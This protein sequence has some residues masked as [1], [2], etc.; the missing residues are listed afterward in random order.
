MTPKPEVTT[1]F[2][3]YTMGCSEEMLRQIGRTEEAEK[4][5]AYTVGAKKAY[6]HYYINQE[7]LETEHMACLVRPLAFDLAPQEQKREIAAALNRMAVKR[8][9]TVGTGFL[10]TPYLL[11]ALAENGYLDTAYRMLENTKASG[12]LAMVSQGA[13]TVWEGYLGFDEAG[14]PKNSSMNHYAMGSVCS[15]L[16][17]YVCGIT[18]VAEN[19]FRIRPLP[20]GSL[21]FAKAEEETP[22]GRI[23]VMWEREENTIRYIVSVP[24]NTTAVLQLSGEPE[25]V[26]VPGEYQF[27]TRNGETL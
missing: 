16:F 23:A 25:Q 12:W 13:T 15:F 6:Q 17:E 20:G 26:L 1:A 5:H 7:L 19:R 14:H 10:A 18:V 24:A 11:P 9:Y 2:L 4:C 27:L 8:D 22:Y 21:Q 3:H